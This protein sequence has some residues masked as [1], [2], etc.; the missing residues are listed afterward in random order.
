MKPLREGVKTRGRGLFVQDW[1]SICS[2]HYIY[3]ETCHN[4]NTGEWYNRWIAYTNKF[5]FWLSPSFW[6]WWVNRKHNK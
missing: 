4:C 6:C 3:D 1:Y 5:V 2:A